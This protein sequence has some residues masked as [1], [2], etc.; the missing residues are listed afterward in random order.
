MDQIK[1]GAFIAA[2]RKEQHLTQEALA[3]ALGV[4]NRSVSRWETG[5]NLPDVSLFTPLCEI[6][7]ITVNE[8]LQGER[9]E[10]AVIVQKA[11]E[12]LLT[13]LADNDRKVRHVNRRLLIV[14]T[15]GAAVIVALLSIVYLMFF[16]PCPS[17]DGDTGEWDDLFP[18]H[19]AYTL[20]LNDAGQPVFK[21]PAKAMRKAKSDCSDS[22]RALQKEHHLLPL[23]RFYYKP[24][25]AWAWQLV[26]SSQYTAVTAQ[27]VDLAMFLDIYEN[28]F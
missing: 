24:Y 19:S 7:G 18:L 28:S 27:G 23:S 26:A 8:L 20:A 11:E 6:L 12:T 22:I 10:E 5:K 16:T 14:S 2:A 15:A 4:S 25:K 21:D 13:A 3:E 17:H 9:M 1:I